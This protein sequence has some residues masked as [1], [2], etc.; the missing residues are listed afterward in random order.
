MDEQSFFQ[1]I[2]FTIFLAYISYNI[3]DTYFQHKYSSII[4]NFDDLYYEINGTMYK[5]DGKKIIALKPLECSRNLLNFNDFDGIKDMVPDTDED[6]EVNTNNEVNVITNTDDEIEVNTNEETN[7]NEINIANEIVN[8]IVDDIIESN[9]EADIVNLNQ[10]EYNTFILTNY[11][12]EVKKTNNPFYKN[13]NVQFEILFE[14]NGNNKEN[15]QL[16][17]NEDNKEN[18]QL[19]DNEI[20]ENTNDIDTE[21]ETIKNTIDIDDDNWKLE[22]KDNYY[23]LKIYGNDFKF[24]FK[25]LFNILNEYYSSSSK[26]NMLFNKNQLNYFKKYIYDSSGINNFENNIPEFS[27]KYFNFNLINL[28]DLYAYINNEKEILN[29][30]DVDFNNIED[31]RDY[32]NIELMNSKN[33]QI[34]SEV[35]NEVISKYNWKWF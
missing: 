14:K 29:Y 24:I 12:D 18:E 34:N 21:I 5:S 20:I 7:E 22:E 4:D 32:Y 19:E 26:I 6:E 9:I 8:E 30:N 28:Y 2:P 13:L 33:N 1:Y 25:K 10:V 3:I 35:N 16:D 23:H 17:D 15:E 11:E 27:Y 31:L